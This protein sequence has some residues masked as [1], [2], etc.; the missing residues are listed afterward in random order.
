[1]INGKQIG[2]RAIEKHDLSQ[3]LA[4]RN[5]PALR[6]FFREHAELN[7]ENQMTWFQG[8]VCNSAHVKMFAI[9]ASDTGEL[10]GACG[11]CA[12]DWVN[13]HA[14]FSIYIGKDDLYIDDVYATDAGAVLL[15]YGFE[16][17]NLHR[18][19]AEIYDIDEQKKNLLDKLNFVFEGRHSQTYWHQ[20]KWHDSLY[21]ASFNPSA[22]G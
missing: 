18:I 22:K 19:W 7:S 1:M 3:L 16:E 4:W 12:I 14:D 9:V 5:K 21:Y 17:L 11:L 13:R 10:I 15:Q 2:L 6:R 8:V 20:G